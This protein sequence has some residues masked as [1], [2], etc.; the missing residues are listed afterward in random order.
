MNL[1]AK[2]WFRQEEVSIETNIQLRYFI[3]MDDEY[4]NNI[5]NSINENEL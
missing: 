5:C 3:E 2:E 1:D 4:R